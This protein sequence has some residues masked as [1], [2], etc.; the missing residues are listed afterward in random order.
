MFI[1]DYVKM[2]VET[3]ISYPTIS[4]WSCHI[5]HRTSTQYVAAMYKCILH[6]EIVCSGLLHSRECTLKIYFI[7]GNCMKCALTFQRIRVET[8]VFYTTIF[9]RSCHVQHS[10]CTQQS[11]FFILILYCKPLYFTWEYFMQW[12]LHITY[13]TEFVDHFTVHVV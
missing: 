7:W 13:C 3:Q 9:K 8:K 11:F 10:T 6:R 12:S 4:Q 1:A 5:Q 2:L